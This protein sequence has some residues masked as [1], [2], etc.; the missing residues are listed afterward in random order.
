MTFPEVQSWKL[1]V[2]Q[3]SSKITVKLVENKKLPEIDAEFL[4][5]LV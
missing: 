5:S 1:M 2:K 4:K 3:L